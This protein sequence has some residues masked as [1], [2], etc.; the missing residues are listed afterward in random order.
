MSP[1]VGGSDFPS[2]NRHETLRQTVDG[3]LRAFSK[4]LRNNE[5]RG[6]SNAYRDHGS[7]HDKKHSHTEFGRVCHFT[8]TAN[9]FTSTTSQLS[10]LEVSTLKNCL[11]PCC[12][13]AMTVAI[14]RILVRTDPP[15]TINILFRK[16][17]ITTVKCRKKV[18]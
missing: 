9:Y 3:I 16:S 5:C 10:A 4:T 14:T 12:L 18:F 1:P 11:D 6:I 15:I 2:N 8:S 13:F 17:E 7:S